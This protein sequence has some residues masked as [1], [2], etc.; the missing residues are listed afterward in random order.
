[1]CQLLVQLKIPPRWR[2]SI[3][4]EDAEITY[5]SQARQ[6]PLRVDAVDK[7]GLG[8]LFGNDGI[9]S[10][11]SVKHYCRDGVIRESIFR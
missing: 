4:G 1:M 9:G 2:Q 7:V 11:V 8:L 5:F 10:A 3:E 6:C